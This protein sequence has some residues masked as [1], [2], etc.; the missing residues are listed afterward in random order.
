MMYF[1]FRYAYQ[2]GVRE[3]A[4]GMSSRRSLRLCGDGRTRR[5]ERVACALTSARYFNV[6]CERL[7]STSNP[8]ES[9]T[10]NCHAT[11]RS[12]GQSPRKSLLHRESCKPCPGCKKCTVIQGPASWYFWYITVTTYSSSRLGLLPCPTTIHMLSFGWA[13]ASPAEFDPCEIWAGH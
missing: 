7:S 13:V 11:E 3:G 6:P 4:T 10:R 9:R 1:P 5:R 12:P 8:A 2:C